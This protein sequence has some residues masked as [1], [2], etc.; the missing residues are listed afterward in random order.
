M[1]K[2]YGSYVYTWFI[3]KNKLDLE[4]L[5]LCR[6]ANE[7]AENWPGELFTTVLKL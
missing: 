4:V 1:V 7:S 3:L 6:V 2:F 5:K